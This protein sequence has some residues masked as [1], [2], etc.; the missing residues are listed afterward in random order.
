MF[1]ILKLLKI[2]IAKKE[3][4]LGYV[5]VPS[6]ESLNIT[7]EITLVAYAKWTIDPVDVEDYVNIVCKSGE[8]DSR[9]LYRLHY[10]R[11]YGTWGL[12]MAGLSFRYSRKEIFIIYR[13]TMKT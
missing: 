8:Y 7:D 11:K 3:C 1:D 2:W 12:T 10:G 6:S 5:E 4:Y 13:Q 9:I